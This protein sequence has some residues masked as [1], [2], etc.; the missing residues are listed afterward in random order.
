MTLLF[1]ARPALTHAG[2]LYPR[3][4]RSCVFS[5]AGACVCAH[6][7]PCAP[8]GSL[9]FAPAWLL[10]RGLSCWCWHPHALSPSCPLWFSLYYCLAG[11]F[12]FRSGLVALGCSLSRRGPHTLLSS[13]PRLAPAHVLVALCSITGASFRAD[14]CPTLA[15]ASAFTLPSRHAHGRPLARRSCIALS[16]GL[17]STR[18]LALAPRAYLAPVTRWCWCPYA[19]FHCARGMTLARRSYFALTLEQASFPCG[20]GLVS[21]RTITLSPHA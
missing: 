15:L 19:L 12:C 6:S 4:R 10:L 8:A 17:V 5:H 3:A 11:S 13:R 16:L 1:S 21:T 14:G 9:F 18:A 2:L 7:L 20:L